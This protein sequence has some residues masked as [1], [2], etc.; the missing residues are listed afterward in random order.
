MMTFTAVALG[1][2]QVL[3]PE[4]GS[5]RTVGLRVAAPIRR[6]GVEGRVGHDLCEAFGVAIEAEPGEERSQHVRIVAEQVLVPDAAAK[7]RF[8]VVIRATCGVHAAGPLA[9]GIPDPLEALVGAP[10]SRA[11]VGG[12]PAALSA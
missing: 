6:H 7:R 8:V 12:Q 10:E 5:R 2:G 3:P 11:L 4:P 1:G 9:G